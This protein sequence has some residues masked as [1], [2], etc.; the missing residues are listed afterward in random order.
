[1]QTL[2][3]ERPDGSVIKYDKAVDVYM[4]FLNDLGPEK[5]RDAWDDRY[6][7]TIQ[8]S[9]RYLLVPQTDIYAKTQTSTD[10]KRD[11]INR[12]AKQLG[13]NYKARIEGDFTRAKSKQFKVVRTSGNNQ[14]QSI[15]EGMSAR[16]AFASFVESVG[17]ERIAALGILR[18]KENIVIPKTGV[19]DK[20]ERKEING[21][22]LV[23]VKMDIEKIAKTINEIAASLKLD[24]KAST[25]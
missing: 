12:M 22:Y 1:M 8:I 20:D 21:C 13:L 17:A 9:K 2:I 16:E 25:Y 11:I 15:Y 23:F 14:N 4:R 10:L 6:F 3:V 19:Y 7:S 24:Y 5:I 18:S